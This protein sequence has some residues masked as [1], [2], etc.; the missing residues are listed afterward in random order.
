MIIVMGT[1]EVAAADRERYLE[2]KRAQV[3]ATLAE[4]GCIG[5]AFAADAGDP[6][7]VHV[8]ER[9]ERMADLGAHVAALRSADPGS[10]APPVPSRVADMAVYE[11]APVRPP[12]A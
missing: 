3:A 9:W 4:E 7:K 1:I 12:W 11:A 8:I 10:S 2:G 6:G 5:Y